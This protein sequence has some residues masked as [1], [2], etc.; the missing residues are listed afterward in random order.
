MKKINYGIDAPKVIRNLILIGI[1]L[2]LIYALLEFGFLPQINDFKF[3]FLS[4]AVCLIIAGLLM[5]A[6][7]KYG[8]FKHRDRILKMHEWKGD[9]KVLDVGTGLGLLMIGAAKRLTTGKSYGVDI[10]NSYDLSSNTIE[11]TKMNIDLEKVSNNTEVLSENILETNFDDN[12]FDIIVSN[13]CLHNLYKEDERKQACI[14]IYRI[15]K[16]GGEAIISD[17][18]HT[19]EYKKEFE[20]L[21]MKVQ[22]KGTY[23]FDT[24]PPLTIIKGIK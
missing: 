14:E 6:Y 1:L 24:F 3:S 5:I 23:F 19:G 9:E 11:K 15:L 21:G 22:K 2:L 20:S 13:L 18:K 7:S 10:F 8:K 4:P 12:Y 17:F 16:P